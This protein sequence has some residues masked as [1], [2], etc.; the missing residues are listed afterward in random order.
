MNKSRYLTAKL[1]IFGLLLHTSGAHAQPASLDEG[2]R[3][4]TALSKNSL[5]DDLLRSVW[6]PVVRAAYLKKHSAEIRSFSFNETAD[7]EEGTATVELLPIVTVAGLRPLSLS[8]SGNPRGGGL[9]YWELRL[10]RLSPEGLRRVAAW[11]KTAPATHWDPTGEDLKVQLLKRP[12][13]LVS[14]LCDLS[15]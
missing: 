2:F 9:A 12:G 7:A 1:C 6:D 11:V 13:N 8:A 15:D 14:L 10:G 4:C 5:A 3:T